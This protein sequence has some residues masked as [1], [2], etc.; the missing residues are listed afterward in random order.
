MTQPIISMI[1]A[2]AKNRVIGRENSLPWHLPEDLKHFKQKTLDK[3]VV[4]GRKTYESVGKPL[5]GRENVIITR[6]ADYQADGC[7]IVTS[8]EQ[9][10]EHLAKVEEI[11]IIG[12][13]EIYRLALPMAHRMYLTFIDLEV[14]G[15]A[16][17]PEWDD[18]VWQQESMESFPAQ[19][20]KP[21][22]AFVEYLRKD[23]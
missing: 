16:Y 7:T 17:F 1:A 6:N 21:G 15:D 12:G 23:F 4:M 10:I 19:D 2:M 3:P 22:Y 18:S 5:P 11:M 8:L 20:S 13:T 9:A 14:D